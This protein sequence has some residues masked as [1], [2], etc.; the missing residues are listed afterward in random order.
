MEEDGN[1]LY[2]QLKRDE[3]E[4]YEIS[5]RLSQAVARWIERVERSDHP[6]KQEKIAQIRKFRDNLP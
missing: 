6:L 1:D 4:L 3:E 2:T 5:W